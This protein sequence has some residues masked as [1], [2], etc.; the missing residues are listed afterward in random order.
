MTRTISLVSALLFACAPAVACAATL[1]FDPQDRTVGTETSFKVA[2]LIDAPTPVNAFDITLRIPRGLTLLGTE[3]GSSIIGYWVEAPRF[4]ERARTL[5]FAGIVPGGYAGS[6]ARLLTLILKA[7][8]EGPLRLS[9]DTASTVLRNDGA[10][11]PDPLSAHSLTLRAEPGR[12]NVENAIP[13]TDPPL[14]FV[15]VVMS[16]PL[17]ADGAPY[18]VF[19]TQDGGSGVARYEVAESPGRAPDP[20]AWAQAESPY[21]LRDASLTS[22]IAVRAID[23]AGNV[24]TALLPPP[25]A[26][27]FATLL[28]RALA[29]LVL[30]CLILLVYA[31][32]V[33]RPLR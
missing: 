11:T 21:P 9:I 7:E 25:R 28:H 1:Y 17:V 10:A 30:A 29:L 5:H 12:E 31:R 23:G 6:G 13:D 19:A 16:D 14:P 33:R 26:D 3:D 15:P 20:S 4:D 27:A 32:T 22:W 24:R 18:L 8:Q 2:A